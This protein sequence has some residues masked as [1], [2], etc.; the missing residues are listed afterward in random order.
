MGDQSEIQVCVTPELLV[1]TLSINVTDSERQRVEEESSSEVVKRGQ[2]GR[3][4]CRVGKSQ[5]ERD[6]EKR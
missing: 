4:Y 6:M 2:M 1:M 3:R 5:E